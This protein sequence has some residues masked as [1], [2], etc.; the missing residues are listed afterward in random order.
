MLVHLLLGS[1]FLGRIGYD[2]YEIMW[3]EAHVELIL[4]L[5]LTLTSSMGYTVVTRHMT[6][7]VPQR[8]NEKEKNWVR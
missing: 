6:V 8:R 4:A 2:L 3:T 1:L 5:T 7:A